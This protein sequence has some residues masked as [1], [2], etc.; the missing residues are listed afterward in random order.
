MLFLTIF[1]SAQAVAYYLALQ[2]G[3]NASQLAPIYKSNIILTVLLAVI[4][5]KE[6]ENL[7]R[8][9]SSAALVTIGVLMIK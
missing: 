7:T 2:V 1:Y 6:K 9:L 4:F 5:L 3:A 8:K